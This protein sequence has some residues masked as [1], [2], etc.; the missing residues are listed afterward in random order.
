[1]GGFK[2]YCS[3]IIINHTDGTSSKFDLLYNSQPDVGKKVLLLIRDSIN[4]DEIFNDETDEL[5]DWIKYCQRKI[6]EAVETQEILR[7]TF[8]LISDSKIPWSHCLTNI[9]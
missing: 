2:D 8:R 1:M 9:L 3:D 4:K 7:K 5:Y 6:S